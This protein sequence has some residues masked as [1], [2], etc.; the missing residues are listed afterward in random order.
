M[1]TSIKIEIT[2]EEAITEI[3]LLDPTGTQITTPAQSG[4][5]YTASVE[6][7]RNGVYKLTAKTAN[8]V[9]EKIMYVSTLYAQDAFT[10]KEEFRN[11]VQQ[12]M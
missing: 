10:T 12:M 3:E 6:P 2:A 11:R 7:T 5:T 8:D 9:N 1:G 4:K